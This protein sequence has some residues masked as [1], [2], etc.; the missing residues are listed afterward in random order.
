MITGREPRPAQKSFTV[1]SALASV[2]LVGVITQTVPSNK[3]A[4]A[5]LGP[6]WSLPA[7]GWLPTK[8]AP[9]PAQSGVNS[10]TSCCFVLPA[11][12]ITAP[13]LRSGSVRLAKP[14]IP[15]IGVHST[16]KSASATASA[17]SSVTSSAMPIAWHSATLSG[18]RT[19]AETRLANPRA[20]AAKPIEPPSRPA[21]MM[22]SLSNGT[23]P[24]NR[25]GRRESSRV[26]NRAKKTGPH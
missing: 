6:V 12:V 8:H 4:C 16:I 26:G 10:A 23:R 14:A 11:S 18:R 24:L 5:A 17:G 19:S 7:I 9:A 21:P 13:G 20:R 15:E 1:V 2:L 25:R 22:V 3:F